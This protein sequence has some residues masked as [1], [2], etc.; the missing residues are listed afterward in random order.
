MV[1]SGLSQGT[2]HRILQKDL[3]FSRICAKFVPRILTPTQMAHRADLAADNLSLL[4][5]GGKQF[6][7]KI[8]SGDETWL[9]CFNP[10]TKQRSSQ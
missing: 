2:V 6:M 1:E 7:E 8:V 4:E 3:N 9:Y 5:E 10:Q